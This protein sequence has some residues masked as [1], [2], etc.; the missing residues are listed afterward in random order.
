MKLLVTGASGFLGRR[1]VAYYKDKHEVIP[2]THADCELTKVHAVLAL[3]AKHQPQVVIHCAAIAETGRCTADPEGSYKVNVTAVGHLAMACEEYGARLVLCSSDQVYC[4]EVLGAP[5]QENEMLFP[6]NVYGQQKLAAERLCRAFSPDSVCLRLTWMYD[7]RIEEGERENFLTTYL[8]RLHTREALTYP[9]YDA[10][11]LTDV[12]E[13]VKNMEAAWQLPDGIYNFGS[14]AD[15]SVCEIAARLAAAEQ[16]PRT[17]TPDLSAFADRPR[18]LRMDT[19]KVQSHGIRF[20]STLAG[21]LAAR[22]QKN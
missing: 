20:A 2:V 5:H 11:G 17:V 8:K 19:A 18:D 12:W 6:T 1:I 10:R 22:K 4:G 13:V 15:G 7:S 9:V 16:P 3:L 21:L 14:E